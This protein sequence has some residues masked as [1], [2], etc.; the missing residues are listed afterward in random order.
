MTEQEFDDLISFVNA[1]L[2]LEESMQCQC[3][4]RRCADTNGCQHKRTGLVPF[5]TEYGTFHLCLWCR[6]AGH[7]GFGKDATHLAPDSSRVDLSEARHARAMD[8]WARRYDALNGAPEGDGD[9]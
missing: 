1:Q 9:R 6:D 8:R 7:M 5:K 4:D 3:E 2:D